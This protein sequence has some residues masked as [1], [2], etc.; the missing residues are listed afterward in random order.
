MEEFLKKVEKIVRESQLA[1]EESRKRGEQFNMFWA[2]GVNH[3][4]NTHS[5]I[6]AELLN[7]QGSHG[8]GTLFLSSFLKICCSNDFKFSPQGV[9][10][11]TEYPIDDGRLDIFVKNK[12]EQVIIIENKIY[13][14]D[15]HEQLKR[16]EGF[17]KKNHVGKYE[18]LYLT[19]YGSEASENSGKD[20]EYTRISYQNEIVNWLG[21][22]I[23]KCIALPLIRETLIQYQNHIKLLTN[24]TMETKEYNE[25][26]SLMAK[27]AKEVQTIYNVDRMKYLEYIFTHYA[28]KKL[29]KIEG[30]EYHEDN[31]FGTRGE[32]GFY[33]RRLDWERCAIWVFTY[34][35]Q[36]DAFMI[37]LSPYK[38]G[39]TTAPQ[40]KLDCLEKKSDKD[41]PYGW[42]DLGEYRDWNLQNNTVPDMISG[43]FVD[44][45]EKRV[46]DILIEINTNGYKL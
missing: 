17:A 42:E 19:L 43:K 24:Q 31:L 35:S 36:L 16:Y 46:K 1:L 13:A 22:C 20:V 34:R 6:I 15:Q 39:E 33:F 27:N 41:W 14:P 18:L 8:Q 7:P 9:Q 30:L 10:V 5:A 21:V 25:L 4:E 45:I 37:G 12:K 26:F 29:K 44:Y 32:R 3:Y 28:Q 23:K 11:C 40:K 38:K 2:C